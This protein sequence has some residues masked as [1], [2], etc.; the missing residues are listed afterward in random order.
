MVSSC[1][2]Q[3]KKLQHQPKNIITIGV[4]EKEGNRKVHLRPKSLLHEGG[5]KFK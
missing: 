3:N 4:V 2:K 5:Q 1:S